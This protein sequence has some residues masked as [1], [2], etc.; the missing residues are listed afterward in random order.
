LAKHARHVVGA[1]AATTLTGDDLMTTG[2]LAFLTETFVLYQRSMKKLLRRP[3]AVYF[4]L[5]QPVIWM[6]LFGQIFNR[7]AGANAQAFGGKSYFQFFVP[8]VLLQTLLFGAAQSGIGI[9]NDMQSGF[10]GKLLTTPV[11]RMAILLGRILGD[12][13]RMILQG[14]LILLI[15]W[16]AGQLQTDRVRY[17]YGLLGVLGALGIALMFGLGLASFN[18]FL[19][20]KTRNTESTFLI[21]NFLTLPL[22]F[23]SSAQLP[24]RLLPDWLQHVARVNPVTYAIDAMRVLLNGPY[25]VP[26]VEPGRLILQAVLILSAIAAVTLTLAVRG[27]RQSLR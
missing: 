17:E 10:L 26:D 24:V 12:L 6:L 14:L 16:L 27:F 20:L 18:V 19:A 1:A 5:I 13:T 3:V 8:S 9:I 2:A 23:T 4:S 25:A 11:H 7:I 21:A 15:A 22:L